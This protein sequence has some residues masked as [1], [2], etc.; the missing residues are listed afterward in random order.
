MP[1][2]HERS[3][4]NILFGD[5]ICRIPAFPMSHLILPDESKDPANIIFIR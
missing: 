5:T 3:Y 2:L 1:L 4:T